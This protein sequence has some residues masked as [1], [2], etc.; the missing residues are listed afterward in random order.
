VVSP[1]SQSVVTGADATFTAEAFDA[2]GNSL[3]DVSTST[4]WSTRPEAGGVWTLNVYTSANVDTWTVT[5]TYSGK[6]DTASLT[7]DPQYLVTVDHFLFSPIGSQT[8]GVAFSVTITAVDA[9][10]HTVTSYTDTNTLS[11]SAATITPTSTTGGFLDGVWTGDVSLDTANAAMTIHTVGT[12]AKLGDSDPFVVVSEISETS[13]TVLVHTTD[14]VEVRLDYQSNIHDPIGPGVQM[15]ELLAGT[16][17]IAIM[18]TSPINLPSHGSGYY[19]IDYTPASPL[20]HGHYQVWFFIL[21]AM[22]SDGGGH[23]YMTKVVVEFD[24]T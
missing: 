7:V 8:V 14:E 20:A 15:G 12:D 6:T 19:V 1:N 13:V 3:G 16:T 21:N 9:D 24:I 11:A 23:Q 22:P 2:Y 18:V 17:P 10:G 4:M 5:A